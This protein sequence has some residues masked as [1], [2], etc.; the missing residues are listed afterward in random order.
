MTSTDAN[1]AVKISALIVAGVYVFRRFTE[2]S[3]EELKAKNAV[4][5]LGQFVLAWSVIYFTLSLAAGPAPALAGPLAYLIAIAVLLTNGLAISKDIRGAL[6]RP[7]E[8]D[9]AWR[10]RRRR[11]HQGK[12]PKG[13]TMNPA[14]TPN[15][16]PATYVPLEDPLQPTR[17]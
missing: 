9:A 14:S 3:P 2:G 1:S 4:A 12:G 16:V 7:A 17:S 11:E 13:S 8:E 5:P 6:A 15:T 10:T